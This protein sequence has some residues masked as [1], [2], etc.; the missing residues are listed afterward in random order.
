[1]DYWL[2]TFI[3][4]WNAEHFAETI[5]QPRLACSVM[6]LGHIC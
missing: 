5:S 2:G 4:F 1:V 6:V 3:C